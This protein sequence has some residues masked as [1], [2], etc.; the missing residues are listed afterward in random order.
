MDAL[1]P[2]R[3]DSAANISM[4]IDKW[5]HTLLK[6][7]IRKRRKSA[8]LRNAKLR[9]E[10]VSTNRVR[11]IMIPPRI[12]LKAK[13]HLDKPHYAKGL[14]QS[15]YKKDWLHKNPGKTRKYYLK[16]IEKPGGKEKH[17]EQYRKWAK[18]NPAKVARRR[19]NYRLKPG[20]KKERAKCVR[21]WRQRNPN[22][23]IEGRLRRNLNKFNL[24]PDYYKEIL[25]RGCGICGTLE[26]L[27]FDHDHKTG[28]FRGLLCSKCNHGIG[29]L[30]DSLE[31]IK[32][33]TDYLEGAPQ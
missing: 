3:E 16:Q 21:L 20:F 5:L 9:E 4:R 23:V 2:W 19:L 13:C 32:L 29:M 8:K 11:P 33:A 22:K 28:K 31:G 1:P 10:A 6:I 7:P 26:N 18:K 14:C 30:G 27:C 25:N 12:R 24:T 17:A 15:C